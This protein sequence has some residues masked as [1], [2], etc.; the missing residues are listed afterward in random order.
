VIIVILL[1]AVVVGAGVFVFIRR[2]NADEFG[3]MPPPDI[4]EL[5]DYTSAPEEEEPDEST[6]FAS[7]FAALSPAV[8]ALIFLVPLVVLGGLVALVLLLLPSSPPPP[9]L[10]PEIEVQSADLVDEE[11]I[12]IEARVILPSDT[13]VDVDLLK[14]GES[15]AWYSQ[16]DVV[17]E[18]GNGLVNITLNKDPDGP[19]PESGAELTVELSAEVDGQTIEDSSELFLP[20]SEDVRAAFFEPTP[21]PTEAP[22]ETPIP[23]EEPE[24]E[25]TTPR[26][27]EDTPEPATPTPDNTGGIAVTVNNGGNVREQPTASSSVV[28]SI[29]LGDEVQVVQKT[30]DGNW[31]QIQTSDGVTGWTSVLALQ[32]D[33]AVIAQIPTQGEDAPPADGEPDQPSPDGGLQVTVN[34]GGNVR[35]RPTTDSSVVGSITLGDQVQVLQKT[36]DNGWYQIQTSDGVT[37]WASVQALRPDASVVDQIPVVQ[38]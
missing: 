33:A 13:Q 36:A 22:T 20:P 6:G 23:T 25:P 10:Q 32:P 27:P 2:R 35:E 4:G 24:E 14:D 9:P 17:V 12:E 34:N 16:D 29:T 28:G 3:D 21:V 15:F 11:T 38:G 19:Q 8:K 7:R 26:I 18:P 30:A 1:L 5:V 31:Y 37:G